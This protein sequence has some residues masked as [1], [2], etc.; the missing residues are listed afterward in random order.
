[1]EPPSESVLVILSLF[2]PIT[3]EQVFELLGLIVLLACSGLIS[4]SEVAFYSL[5]AADIGEMES[6][7]SRSEKL[8]IELL[9]RPKLLLATIL[10]ANNFINIAIV[11]L[12]T[13]LMGQL[14]NFGDDSI[15][16]FIIQVVLITFIILLFGE[17]LP[18]V[19]AVRNKKKLTSLMALPIQ[20]IQKLFYP[21][22]IA[23]VRSTSFIDKKIK[24]RVDNISVDNLSHAL[25]LTTDETTGEEEKRIL[26]GI[27]NFGNTDVKQIMISRVDVF[28]LEIS[29]KYEE[30]KRQIIEAGFSRIPV[31]RENFDKIEGVLYVK[32][33]LPHISK[34]DSFDWTKLLRAPFFVPENKK[35]DDLLNEI[36]EKKIH[37]AIVVDEYGGT[38]GIASLED[39]IEEIVGDI[40]DEFDVES[41]T[42]SKLDDQNFI[43][44]G[45]TSLKD[46][47]R[48]ADFEETIFENE[49]G[50][51]DTV[52]GFII[53]IAGKIPKKGEAIEFNQYTFTVEA[54]DSR[55][56][57]TVKV[58][59]NP[60]QENESID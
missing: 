17:V 3:F 46:F 31:Y 32:D 6:S 52:A 42:Y 14:F 37:L 36:K 12:S 2:N 9:E 57:S 20:A 8:V 30:V 35:I 7:E 45:K 19:Y 48:I 15:V 49:K 4:G 10:I 51:S 24:S 27:V 13:A 22:S 40:S 43:L 25:E 26:E 1:M 44:E 28:S 60:I 23:L 11:I 5:E 50:E 59:I 39:I 41:V 38:S 21:V 47:Y 16:G 53:E 34:D 56:I 58:T 18:K 29:E 55:K 54:A 33:L